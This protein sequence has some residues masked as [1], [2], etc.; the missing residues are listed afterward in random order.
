MNRCPAPTKRHFAKGKNDPGFRT[1][2]AIGADLA[3]RARAAGFLFHAV[4]ADSAYGDQDG[5]RGELA[6]AGL[7]F[8]MALKPRHGTW[9][10][11]RPMPILP[12]TRAAPWPRTGPKTPATGRR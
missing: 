9:G 5:F 10:W 12:R 4:A 3:V 6:E 2:L 8:V 1:K 11:G 7:P